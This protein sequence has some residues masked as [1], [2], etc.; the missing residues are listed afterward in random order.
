MIKF[1]PYVAMQCICRG[2]RCVHVCAL[3]SGCPESC[4]FGHEIIFL[5]LLP[6]LSIPFSTMMPQPNEKQFSTEVLGRSCFSCF[7]G[8]SRLCL[9]SRLCFSGSGLEA[10]GSCGGAVCQSVRSQRAAGLRGAQPPR[11]AQ[12]G[13]K[14]EKPAP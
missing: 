8:K 12:P 14:C 1:P 11:A 5:C 13:T 9:A 6:L 10:G 3:S 4:Q 2:K 7:K